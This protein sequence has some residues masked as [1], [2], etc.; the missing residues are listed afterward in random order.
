LYVGAAPVD[1]HRYPWSGA[2]SRPET[3]PAR[4]THTV[5][6]VSCRRK[7][8]APFG[9]TLNLLVALPSH[10]HVAPGICRLRTMQ[11]TSLRTI[12]AHRQTARSAPPRAQRA[13]CRATV[14]LLTPRQYLRQRR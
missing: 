12:R 6:T 10:A 3:I 5:N 2:A 1:D 14:P 13:A 4:P 7:C 9:S 11:M 8:A